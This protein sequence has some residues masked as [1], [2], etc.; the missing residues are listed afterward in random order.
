MNIQ[1]FFPPFPPLCNTGW[2]STETKTATM[3]KVFFFIVWFISSANKS[4]KTGANVVIFS[5]MLITRLLLWSG[6]ESSLLWNET[7]PLCGLSS[8]LHG[9][10]AAVCWRLAPQSLEGST[11][12][13]QDWCRG[14][15]SRLEQVGLRLVSHAMFCSFGRVC[16]G[17]RVDPQNCWVDWALIFIVHINVLFCQFLIL[18]YHFS[19][20][21]FIMDFSLLQ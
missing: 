9:G 13:Q 7:G 17:Y 21:F 19:F 15:W 3:G 1:T 14:S 8:R 12:F 20:L 10:V 5:C 18:F 16:L 11:R 6:G 2:E 4:A